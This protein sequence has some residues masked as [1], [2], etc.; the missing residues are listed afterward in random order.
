VP[1]IAGLVADVLAEYPD[2]PAKQILTDAAFHLRSLVQIASVRTG[3]T[4][5][6]RSVSG[7]IASHPTMREL[8]GLSFEEPRHSPEWGAVIWARQHKHS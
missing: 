1:E 6:R 7:S 2:E 8:I 4:D 3:T 5:C